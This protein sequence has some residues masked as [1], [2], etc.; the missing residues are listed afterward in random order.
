MVRTIPRRIAPHERNSQ[1]ATICAPDYVF[2]LPISVLAVSG[3]NLRRSS[4]QRTIY[5]N[6]FLGTTPIPIYSAFIPR[7]IPLPRDAVELDLA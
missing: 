4:A 6:K 7:D 2:P 3:N 1:H 5:T